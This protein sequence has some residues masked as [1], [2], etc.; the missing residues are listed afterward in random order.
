M[1]IKEVLAR[2]GL[3]D[4]AVRL[5]IS[6]GL[7]RPQNTP[8]YTGRKNLDFSEEDITKLQQVAVLRKADFSIEQIRLLKQD[9]R[10]AAKVLQEYVLEKRRKVDESRR[11]LS[12]LATIP[13][14]QEIS[15]ELICSRI[16]GGLQEQPVPEED[17]KP[18]IAH[19]IGIWVVRIASLLAS[20]FFLFLFYMM[21][22]I[23]KAEYPFARYSHEFSHYLGILYP[24]PA[25]LCFGAVFVLFVCRV[26]SRKARRRRSIIAGILA[27]VGFMSIFN[28]FGM[29]SILFVSPVY[30]ETSNPD[31]YLV[32]GDY[33][34]Y[35]GGDI[36][37]LF[38]SEIPD[39]AIESRQFMEFKET[40]EYYYY[41]EK[42][43]DPCYDVYAQWELS[44]EELE[45][46]F[47]RQDFF[48]PE[49]ATEE[50]RWGDWVCRSYS[51]YGDL[52]SE[53]KPIDHD[54]YYNYSYNY[55]IFAY[56]EEENLVRYIASYAMDG[57]KNGP[58]FLHLDW[59]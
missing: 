31:N 17:L 48:F 18:S 28:P 20:L 13:P 39:S 42:E 10:T 12:A 23:I 37:M 35:Y 22:V 58:Y 59:E 33:V 25:F 57:S 52:L 6:E 9:T 49:G 40:T 50:L 11:I 30:S 34:Q 21:V 4:R 16:E 7:I 51:D 38:P 44:D 3:T 43:F 14:E 41:Y 2:T 32:F 15:V 26:L 54:D 45:R 24:L 8:S 5:Y 55:L 19:R 29:I 47:R 53:V 36:N 56:N 46:E 1:K 27:T